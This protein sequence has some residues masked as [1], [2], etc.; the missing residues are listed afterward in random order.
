MSGSRNPAATV[1]SDRRHVWHPYTQAA[2]SPPPIAIAR[3]QGAWLWDEAGRGYIDAISSWWVTLHG[4]AQPEIAAAIARQATELEQVIFAGC[5]HRPAAELAEKLAAALP[6]GLTRV[7]YSDDGSTAVEVALKMALQYWHNQGQTQRT[8]F[9]ALDYAYHGDTAAAMAVGAPSPFTAAFAPLLF[10][11][12]RAHAAYC[13]RC[14]M[15]L[16]RGTCHIECLDRMEQLLRQDADRTAAVILE[17]L[18]QGAGGMIVHPREF[19][20]GARRLCDHYGVLL[21]ADEVLTGF[22]RTGTMFACQQAEVT[23]DI[24]CLSKGLTGGFLPLAATVCREEIYLAFHSTDRRKTLFHGHSYTANPLG[25]AAA[26][27]SLELLEQRETWERIERIGRQHA[28]RLASLT[29]EAKTAGKIAD[30]RQ[31]GT[32]A[33][34]ELRG[35]AKGEIAEEGY[36]S[37]LGLKLQQF[38]LDHGVLLRPLGPIVYVLPPYSITEADLE[39]VWDVIAA[40]LE[41]I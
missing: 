36:L 29:A 38:Y 18:L 35:A 3:G 5:T 28:A 19:L 12:A 39:T 41:L 13:H 7:F 6:A 27:A 20:A 25:C 11:V 40:S 16:L 10:P 30:A 22:G 31:I 23:P 21:I 1:A 17:P 37:A 24:I 9:V 2:V 33:A 4:H 32:A 26:L 8:G 14:P 34:L 15:G